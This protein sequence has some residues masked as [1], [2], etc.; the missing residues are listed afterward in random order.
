MN[1]ILLLRSTLIMFYLTK[2][3]SREFGG[4]TERFVFDKG[5]AIRNS[6]RIVVYCPFIAVV[7]FKYH[8]G[9]YFYLV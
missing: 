1:V 4:V 3:L 9:S 7:V 6:N 8:V 5:Q 2:F